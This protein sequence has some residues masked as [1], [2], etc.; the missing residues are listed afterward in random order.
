AWVAATA[1]SPNGLP[2]LIEVA[3]GEERPLDGA[4]PGEVPV[5]FDAKGRLVLMLEEPGLAVLTT[6]D[7][8]TGRRAAAGK[9]PFAGGSVSL[10]LSKDLGTRVTSAWVGRSQ[11]H[12]VTELP[13]AR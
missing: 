3:T 1:S 4:A 13:L 9:V 8:A 10:F 6:V 7:P 12:L 11:I 2:F 5:R